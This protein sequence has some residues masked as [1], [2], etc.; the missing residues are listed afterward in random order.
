MIYLFLFIKFDQLSPR[1]INGQYETELIRINRTC[2]DFSHRS[3]GIDIW[4]SQKPAIRRLT[5]QLRIL[6][7]VTASLGF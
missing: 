3:I 2:C 5:S 1:I 6:G 4:G 7:S